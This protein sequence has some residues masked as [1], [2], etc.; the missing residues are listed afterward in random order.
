[1]EN[2]KI[3][4]SPEQIDHRFVQYD[5]ENKIIYFKNLPRE[6]FLDK[7]KG[8]GKYKIPFILEDDM[9]AS[10]VV[11][12]DFHF[13]KSF[14]TNQNFTGVGNFSLKSNST[15]D[16]RNYPWYKPI[17]F[18]E[19]KRIKAKIQKLDSI[20]NMEIKFSEN[21]HNEFFN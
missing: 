13:I 9:G 3:T 17:V 14:I 21:M 10:N 20:G 1:M 8:E 6:V 2:N 15:I 4:I 19:E 18:T 7:H 12:L 11:D 16:R 5:E